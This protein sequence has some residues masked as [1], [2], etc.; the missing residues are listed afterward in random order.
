[1]K[2]SER[3]PHVFQNSSEKAAT[4]GY[5]KLKH[6]GDDYVARALAAMTARTRPP[7]YHLPG[8][9]ELIGPARSLLYGRAEQLGG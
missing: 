1:V 5:K 3:D 9:T 6:Q 2:W 8:D 7:P 4:Q